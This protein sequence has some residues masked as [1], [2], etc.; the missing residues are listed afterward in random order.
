[1]ESAAGC[2]ANTRASFA[3]FDRAT[4]SWKTSQLCL[5]GEWSAF[6]ETWPRAG[7]TRSGKAY[8]LPTLARRTEES[9]SGFSRTP[10]TGAIRFWPTPTQADSDGRTTRMKSTDPL[11]SEEGMHAMSLDRAV[12]LWPTPQAHDVRERGNTEADHHY[13]P[14]DLANAVQM[15]PT[16]SAADGDRQSLTY[17][18]NHNPTLLGAVQNWRTPQS[19]NWK[20][21]TSLKWA[22]RTTGDMT[23]SLAGQ[24]GGQLNPTWVEWLMGYP[25]GWTALEDSATPSSRKSRNG[26]GEG[27]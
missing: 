4:S 16:P 5:D 12:R 21:Q 7:M 26:S 19:R 6:S 1:M 24:V 10:R 15:W 2:G 27:S 11:F 23:P 17:P 14:H 25:L 9:E 22:S 20:G 8:E 18:G 13:Y 3:N